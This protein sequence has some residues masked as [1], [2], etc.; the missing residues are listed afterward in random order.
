[1]HTYAYLIDCL[2]YTHYYC[3]DIELG[4]PMITLNCTTDYAIQS[5]SI[6]ISWLLN[7]S[8]PDVF[9]NY[10]KGKRVQRCEAE[11]KCE[12]GYIHLVNTLFC[13][14]HICIYTIACC[15]ARPT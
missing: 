2:Y 11:I 12:N 9:P 15:K 3:F 8:Q 14:I 4:Y 6:H 10:F 7:Y 5:R 13:C 1:M